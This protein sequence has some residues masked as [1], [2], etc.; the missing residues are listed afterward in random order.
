MKKIALILVVSVLFFAA[1]CAPANTPA[2]ATPVSHNLVGEWEYAMTN[3]DGNNYDN[4]TITFTGTPTQG[5][6]TLVN[7]YAVEYRG[8]YTVTGD[9]ISLTGDETW[10]GRFT[11]GS[12]MDGTWHKEDADGTWTA[13]KK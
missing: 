9:V 13:V 10:Q 11:D 6:W 1:G 3:S 8:S 7:F 2:T 4:G 5:E 12:H